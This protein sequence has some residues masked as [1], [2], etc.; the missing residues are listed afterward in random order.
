MVDYEEDLD[1]DINDDNKKANHSDN[2][3]KDCTQYI[4]V[5]YLSNESFMYLLIVNDIISSS[6]VGQAQYFVFDH[7]AKIVFQGIIYDT[8]LTK[9]L[10]VE[11]TQFKAL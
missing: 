2:N 7:Y 9:V 1:D 11:K 10:T 6:D 5:I 8:G 3:D 4:I